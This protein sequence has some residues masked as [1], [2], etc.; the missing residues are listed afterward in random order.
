[1]GIGDKTRAKHTAEFYS[2]MYSHA[3][4]HFYFIIQGA[5]DSRK[6]PRKETGLRSFINNSE[7]WLTEGLQEAGQVTWPPLVATRWSSDR[8][9]LVSPFG[10]VH[11]EHA[12]SLGGL[13]SSL[14]GC[15]V[16]LGGPASS[17]PL[18]GKP[19][20]RRFGGANGSLALSELM[21]L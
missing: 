3:L 6:N 13:T 14:Y 12:S 10:M 15:L 8:R 4:N 19:G 2:I 16:G 17:R 11:R 9:P 7:A 1:M 5:T 21:L 18:S 20:R